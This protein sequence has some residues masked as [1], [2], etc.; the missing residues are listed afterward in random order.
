MMLERYQR[1]LEKGLEPYYLK[2]K[3]VNVTPLFDK[4]VEELWKLHDTQ[5]EDSIPSLELKSELAHR[6]LDHCELCEWRCG[7]NRNR[8]ELGVCGVFAEP[9]VSPVFLHFG[10]EDVLVP[11]HTVFFAGCNFNCIYCQNYDISQ[12]PDSG[13]YVRPEV[14]SE[15]LNHGGGRNVN[16]VG[17]DPTPN[18]A[19]ITEVLRHMTAPLP[20]IWNSNMY[21]TEEGM[22]LSAKLMDVYLTDFKYGNDDCAQRLSG[23]RDY[24]EIV[25]RNH[26]LAEKTGDIII[27]HLVLPGHIDCCTRPLLQWIDNNLDSPYVNIMKQYR[28][29]YRVSECSEID[30]HL[31]SEENRTID[32]LRDEYANLSLSNRS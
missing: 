13:S 2:A 11:S 22:K 16:W 9:K 30:R 5:L 8:G 4:T 25:K 15:R 24:T 7:V 28:P 10:E 6:M 32:E 14:L 20:Q 1:I 29:V 26:L 21:L 19:Y 12:R 3:K 31:S 17:G 18:I 23:V 27:R